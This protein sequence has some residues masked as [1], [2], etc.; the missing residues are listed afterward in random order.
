M[1]LVQSS[2]SV[3]WSENDD[4]CYGDDER[5]GTTLNARAI[6]HNESQHDIME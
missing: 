6:D 5:R 3:G 4:A 2:Q 1:V